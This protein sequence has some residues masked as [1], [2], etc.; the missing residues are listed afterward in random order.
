MIK[1]EV[2]QEDID[3]AKE[4]LK[5]VTAV[6]TQNC[7]MA[8]VGIRLFREDNQTVH[9]GIDS[10]RVYDYN[11]NTVREFLYGEDAVSFVKAFDKTHDAEPC[12][13]HLTE[14]TRR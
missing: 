11:H 3:K 8:Q 14:I 9:A 5:D 7:V 4:A 12:T 6:V 10:M 2:T 13:V 1:I